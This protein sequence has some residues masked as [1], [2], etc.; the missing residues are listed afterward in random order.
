MEFDD[1][2]AF[3]FI[4][5]LHVLLVLFYHCV[6]GCM[7]CVLLFNCVSYVFLLLCVQSSLCSVFI[8]PTGT[9]QLP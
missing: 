1:Y 2:M 3:L 5:F 4:K 7:F 9:L 8:V 6:Y